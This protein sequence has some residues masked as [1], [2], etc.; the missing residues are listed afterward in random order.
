MRPSY[1]KTVFRLSALQISKIQRQ[2]KKQTPEEHSNT[3]KKKKKK[4]EKQHNRLF[5]DA[6]RG[7][8]Y[9]QKQRSQQ[10]K[11]RARSGRSGLR[12][13][14]A[15]KQDSA[16]GPGLHLWCVCDAS[17]GSPPRQ[18][19]G[20]PAHR[21]ACGAWSSEGPQKFRP[22]EAVTPHEETEAGQW[23]PLPPGSPPWEVWVLRG[24]R[25]AD[26]PPGPLLAPLCSHIPLPGARAK[27]VQNIWSPT[28]AEVPGGGRSRLPPGGPLLGPPCRLP[29]ARLPEFSGHGQRESLGQK[30]VLP[31]PLWGELAP[32]SPWLFHA[33]TCSQRLSPGCSGPLA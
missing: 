2:R 30:V 8:S 13:A 21:T 31:R 7:G 26:P 15:P 20:P 12:D 17:R 28:S 19:A 10:H 11:G 6:S 18:A 29:P 1:Q 23:R 33:P 32:V 22:Q 9:K 3:L 4:Q 14:P 27:H 25:I 16:T 24:Q 5:R